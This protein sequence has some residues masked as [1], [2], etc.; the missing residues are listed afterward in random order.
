MHDGLPQAPRLLRWILPAAFV[1][2]IVE[3][4]YHDLLA[5]SLERGRPALG[6]LTKFQFVL[7][8]LWTAF[9]RWIFRSRRL[10]IITAAVATT[11]AVLIIVRMR[12]DY[13]ASPRYLPRHQRAR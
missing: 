12:M 7:A 8:C 1:C 3:P 5:S 2:R 11:L 10:R 9:P 6:S 4:A 13:G